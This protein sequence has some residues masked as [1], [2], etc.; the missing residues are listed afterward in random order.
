MFGETGQIPHIQH[1]IFDFVYSCGMH[2]RMGQWGGG[3][4][5]LLYVDN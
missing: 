4:G 2:A 5:D 1:T 3:G